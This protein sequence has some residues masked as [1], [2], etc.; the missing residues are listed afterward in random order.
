MITLPVMH[1]TTT[2]KLTGVQIICP[3]VSFF[4]INLLDRPSILQMLKRLS[5]NPP[6]VQMI[7]NSEFVK[8]NEKRFTMT[9][10][11]IQSYIESYLSDNLSEQSSQ[12]GHITMNCTELNCP[13]TSNKATS[14]A[15]SLNMSNCHCR[16]LASP[17][18]HYSWILCGLHSIKFGQW[19]Q[20]I[21]IKG[22][23]YI[24]NTV[25][26]SVMVIA[27]YP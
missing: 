16:S 26:R 12:N 14:I 25:L 3:S 7:T 27:C 24:L 5:F 22:T 9:I 21:F 8:F 15:V 6:P 2:I 13:L 11:S 1:I 4:T 18:E 19:Q 23:S 20:L 10:V 17:L